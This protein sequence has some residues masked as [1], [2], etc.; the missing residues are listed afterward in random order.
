MHSWLLLGL[1][2]WN[3]SGVVATACLRI[4]GG[5]VTTIEK[6][7]PTAAVLLIGYFSTNQICGGSIINQRHILTAAHCFTFTLNAG[8][9][10]I[11]VGSSMAHSGGTT[12]HIDR[13]ILHPQWNTRT[14]DN[15]VAIMRTTTAITYGI[16]VQPANL[17]ESTYRLL[18]N[19]SVWAVGW[20][21]TSEYGLPSEQLRDVNVF[22]VNSDICRSRFRNHIEITEN[23]ICTGWLDIGGHDQCSRDS[24]SPVY[25][26]N[27]VIGFSSMGFG[28]ARP[29]YPGV[30]VRVSR[31]SNWIKALTNVKIYTKP[32]SPAPKRTKASPMGIAFDIAFSSIEKK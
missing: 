4:I 5:T 12:H 30:N 2:F 15:D 19:D 28:C 22:V 10:L 27:T 18:D 6:Y 25:H 29:C 16:T 31:F 14:V 7:P 21:L 24:G 17:A 8:V 13:I 32:T 1:C 26:H 3:F 11:R 9:Y 20:G 23:M